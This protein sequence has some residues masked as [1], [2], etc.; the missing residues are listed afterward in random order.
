[1]QAEAAF[2]NT[3]ADERRMQGLLTSQTIT[4]KQYDDAHTRYVAARETYG[5]LRRGLRPDEIAGARTRR[6]YAAAQADLLQKKLRDCVLLAPAG[7]VVTLRAIEPGELVAPGM[8]V[9][10]ITNL[11][12]VTMMIYV[13]EAALG[14][15]RLGQNAEVSIDGFREKTFEGTVVYIAPTAEFTPKNVQTKEERT[16][17]VF[18]VK[19]EV[20]NDQE[21]LKPGLPADARLR[22]G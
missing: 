14:R 15:V 16:K 4:Q 2:R 3:E 8:N 20:R 7:G 9:F 10:R 11:E 13:N 6:E 12:R 19:L 21:A 22:V 1:M 18:G 17:L 5:K